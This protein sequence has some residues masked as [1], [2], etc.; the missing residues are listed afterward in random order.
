[1][2]NLYLSGRDLGFLMLGIVLAI[3]IGGYFNGRFVNESLKND[4]LKWL[5]NKTEIKEI[6]L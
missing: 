2:K 1:M 4:V 6:E 3:F 5:D